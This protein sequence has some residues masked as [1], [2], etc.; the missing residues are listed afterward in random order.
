MIANSYTWAAMQQESVFLNHAE[1]ILE[2]LTKRK[3]RAKV[4]YLATPEVLTRIAYHAIGSKEKLPPAPAQADWIMI[5]KGEEVEV[6]KLE[7]V[8][9]SRDKT[10]VRDDDTEVETRTSKQPIT[11]DP[12]QEYPPKLSDR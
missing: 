1:F 5:I 10:K 8:T 7:T 9:R 4:P 3:K 2:S 12:V 6:T 11:E